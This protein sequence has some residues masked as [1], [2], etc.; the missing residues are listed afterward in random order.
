MEEIR[1][2]KD[3]TNRVGKKG[4]RRFATNKSFLFGGHSLPS[5]SPSVY[6]DTPLNLNFPECLLWSFYSF[7][8]EKEISI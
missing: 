8:L 2:K 7:P 5:S 4:P 6:L 3:E 1:Q